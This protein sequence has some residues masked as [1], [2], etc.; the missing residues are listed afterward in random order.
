MMVMTEFRTNE[1]K[2]FLCRVILWQLKL[3][4]EGK[5]IGITRAS[6][7]AMGLIIVSALK[8]VKIEL[9]DS[10]EVEKYSKGDEEGGE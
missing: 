10:L 1:K 6:R 9:V 7:W 5:D 3:L 2:R 8:H 4:Q